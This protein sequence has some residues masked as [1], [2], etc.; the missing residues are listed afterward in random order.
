MKTPDRLT[1]D[2]LVA[3][4]RRR[5]GP[6]ATRRAEQAIEELYRRHS[7]PLFAFLCRRVG[8]HDAEDLLQTVWARVL[9]ALPA[10]DG[11]SHFRGWLFTVARNL[12]VDHHRR[13]RQ[14]VPLGSAA[15]AVD[16]RAGTRPEE[17]AENE[18]LRLALERCF[19][20]LDAREA[21]VAR[22]RL[23]GDSYKALA[24]RLGLTRERTYQLF[25]KAKKKLEDCLR[26]A[27]S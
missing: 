18:E 14:T 16:Q 13:R 2:D 11:G 15:E 26:R 12:V 22:G 24:E 21:A 27:L 19:G 9:Q 8:R 6:A 25:F 10:S 20:K 4:A 1:D 5:D 23:A 3:H 17:A 7:G